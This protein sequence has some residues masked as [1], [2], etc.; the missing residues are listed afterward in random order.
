VICP[1]CL[2]GGHKAADG[3]G[4]LSADAIRS[5]MVSRLISPYFPK[6]SLIL[7]F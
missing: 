3:I 4:G 5:F 1:R 6:Y 2:E 7:G